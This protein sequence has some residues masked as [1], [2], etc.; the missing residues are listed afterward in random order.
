M[1]IGLVVESTPQGMEAVV[2]PKL[3]RLLA[4]DSGVPI[5]CVVRTMT[6]KKLL[7]LGAA[8]TARNLLREN[9]DRVV[10]LWDENPPWTPQQDIADERCWHIERDQLITNLRNAHIDRRK[11]GLVCIEREFETWLLHDPQLIRDVISTP[12]HKAK[13]KVPKPLTIDDPKAALMSLFSKNKTRY[14]PDVAARKFANQF[15][16]LDRLK[17]CDTFRYFAQNVLGSLPNGWQPCVYRPK[18]PRQ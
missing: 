10:V 18:G 6:N 15:S 1:K 8:D 16:R 5:E 17:D 4:A 7:I 2:C 3:L 12:T 11:V 13:V 9:C 14:N